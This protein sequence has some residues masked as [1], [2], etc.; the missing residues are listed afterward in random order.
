MVHTPAEENLEATPRVLLT[1]AKKA[2]VKLVAPVRPIPAK[3]ALVTRAKKGQAKLV[4]PV[5]HTP[6]KKALVTPARNAPVKLVAHG[7]PIPAE[8]NLALVEA[9]ARK[10]HPRNVRT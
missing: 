2:P 8:A 9:M 4:A 6:A 10:L 5:L 3:K 1:P 7:L